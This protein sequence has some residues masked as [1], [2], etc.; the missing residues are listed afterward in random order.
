MTRFPATVLGVFIAVLAMQ[1][2]ET[3]PP[4]SKAFEPVTLANNAPDDVLPV[5]DL[6]VHPE[7]DPLAITVDNQGVVT[8]MSDD[9]LEVVLED[10]LRWLLPP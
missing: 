1:S 9:T 6:E 7:L 8:F 2:C 3:P 4:P 10:L 5:P